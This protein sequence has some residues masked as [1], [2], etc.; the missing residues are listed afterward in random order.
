MFEIRCEYLA[1]AGEVQARPRD[2][3]GQAGDGRG[4]QIVEGGGPLQRR[5]GAYGFFGVV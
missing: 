1:K 3:G 4:A 2:Q 5:R